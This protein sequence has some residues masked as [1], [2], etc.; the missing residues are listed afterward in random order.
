MIGNVGDIV[1]NTQSPTG[2]Q[3]I[4]LGLY[5]RWT[6]RE[7]GATL[8][9]DTKLR[10]LTMFWL[11]H[12]VLTYN[13]LYHFVIGNRGSGKTYG[14]KKRGIT[15]LLKYRSSIYLFQAISKCEF[16]DIA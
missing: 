3:Y 12:D 5:L 2:I 16:E 8:W 1:Y 11:P 7:R 14:F 4:G 10:G 15:K 9:N 6:V 13:C